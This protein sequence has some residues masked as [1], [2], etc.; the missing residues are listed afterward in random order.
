MILQKKSIGIIGAGNMGGAIIA[1]LAKTIDPEYINV[2]DTD[3]DRLEGLRLRFQIKTLNSAL[4]TANDSDI[5]IIAVKPDSVSSLLKEI[6]AMKKSAVIVSI[7]AGIKIKTI[8]SILGSDKKIVRVMPN[9][10]CII[11]EGIS[12]I[13]SN[14]EVDE[15]SLN[16]VD[17]V[18]KMIG[19]TIRVPEKM[20]DAVTGLSGSGPAYVYTFIHALAD[21]GVKM[22]IPR[23]KA[24]LLAAHTVAGSAKLVLETMEHPMNLRTMVASPGGTTIDGIHVLEKNGFTGIVMEAVEAAANKSKKLGEE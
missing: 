8:E 15:L 11:G 19:H 4:E 2:F 1:G 3:S 18:F 9:T 13:S 6:Q 5:I 21:G 14:D 10:P 17:E 12:A 7:A 24:A 23:D 16:M 22:G 20:M